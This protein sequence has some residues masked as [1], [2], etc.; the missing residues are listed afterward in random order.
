MKLELVYLKPDSTFSKHIELWAKGRSIE[1]M[2]YDLKAEEQVTDGLLLINENQ[3]IEKEMDDLHALFDLKHLPTQKIDIN[4]TLQVAISNYQMWQSN[5]KCKNI[6]ILGSDSLIENK[7]LDRF[8][9][10]IKVN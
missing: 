3:T 5:F 10:K 2:E 7:N 1:T 8:L 9:L 4:G 6:L